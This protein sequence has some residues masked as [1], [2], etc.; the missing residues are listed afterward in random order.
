MV[1]PALLRLQ[2]D[3]SDARGNV[4]RAQ[5]ALAECRPLGRPLCERMLQERRQ[6]YERAKER[7]EA[8]MPGRSCGVA[9]TTP[10]AGGSSTAA[11]RQRTTHGMCG[12]RKAAASVPRRGWPGATWLPQKRP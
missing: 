2:I 11:T 5:L 4:L 10:P 9:S 1:A 8:A 12:V 6:Q 7:L 3:E